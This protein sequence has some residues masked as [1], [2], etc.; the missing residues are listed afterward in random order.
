MKITDEEGNTSSIYAEKKSDLLQYKKMYLAKGG[1]MDADTPLDYAKGGSIKV[2]DKV[3]YPKGKISGKVKSIKDL[4]WERELTIEYDD[5]K[6][7][8]EGESSVI[9]FAKGGRTQGYNDKLDESL[10]KR[11]GKES[12]KQQSKKDRR[13][14][15]KGMEKGSG[16]RAYS[17]VSTMDVGDRMMAKGGNV[18][19]RFLDEKGERKNDPETIKE[20]T[21]YVMSLPQTKKSHYNK[22]TEKYSPKR[23]KLHREIINKFK[24]DLVCIESDE[25]IAIL[26]GGSPASGKS[27]FLKKYA[28]YLLK[29]EL[30]RIDADE[31]RAMLPEYK[32]WNASAT[33]NETQDIVKTLLSDRTIGVPCKYDLIFDGT[34]TSPKKYL[35]LI[36]LLKKIGYKVFVVFIDKV[37]KD[38][39]MKRAMDRYKK[40]GRFVPPFVIEEFFESGK[41]S[42]AKVKSKVDG[43]MIVDGSDSNYKVSEQ[44]GL[45]LPKT[46]KYGRL[47]VPLKKSI[48][49]KK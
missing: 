24:G 11:K 23:Q 19:K 44:K 15:S 4:G 34:M 28:P 13:N 41:D 14:E 29:E 10:G 46:R 22:T 43:Y 1:L 38:V 32:G 31:V 35:D 8:K 17:S 7:I 40:S 30:L 27:T 47:G 37:P 18:P 36:K 20:L 3:K 2:G 39:I 9:K 49:R 16:R 12:T 25:P 45:K 21:K 48:K 33:H 42:L 5:G 6:I 26:M